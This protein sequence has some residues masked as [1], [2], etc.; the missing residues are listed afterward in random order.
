MALKS[1][2]YDN[3]LTEE[4]IAMRNR[5]DVELPIYEPI[6][7]LKCW[8]NATEKDR[9]IVKRSATKGN[10]PF[11]VAQFKRLMLLYNVATLRNLTSVLN[12]VNSAVYLKITKIVFESV[13]MRNLKTKKLSF[14]VSHEEILDVAKRINNVNLLY[15]VTDIHDLIKI[16]TVD[17][18]LDCQIESLQRLNKWANHFLFDRLHRKR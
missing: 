1:S 13:L 14:I 6:N 2:E 4:G 18:I 9:D 8:E 16:L 12:A 5:R 3:R 17:N 7:L 15:D 10:F 11:E